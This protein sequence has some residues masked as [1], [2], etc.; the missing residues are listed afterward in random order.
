MP[1]RRIAQQAVGKRVCVL[2][3][4]LTIRVRDRLIGVDQ[5]IDI[6][7][8]MDRLHGH[9]VGQRLFRPRHRFRHDQRRRLEVG[10]GVGRGE[11]PNRGLAARPRRA[12]RPALE[13]H[14]P[15]PQRGPEQL[16]QLPVERLQQ[17]AAGQRRLANRRQRV[18]AADGARQRR[19]IDDQGA[20][21]RRAK[22][23][24]EKR[25]ALGGH[26][27]REQV[28]RRHDPGIPPLER[29]E[30]HASAL[31]CGR[32]WWVRPQLYQRWSSRLAQYATE[33]R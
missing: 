28:D 3:R 26:Q 12:A 5:W 29:I 6:L 24:R 19:R 8:Q 30:T 33:D 14:H 18:D 2:E 31:G 21:D 10:V 13:E 32:W 11:Q 1:D 23:G 27:R 4:L 20:G 16:A 9:L 25:P 22:L 7:Q 17:R 15:A